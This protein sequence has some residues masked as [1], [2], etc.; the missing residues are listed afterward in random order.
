MRH[1]RHEGLAPVRLF[2]GSK[3]VRALLR[4]NSMPDVGSIGLSFSARSLVGPGFPFFALIGSAAAE[5]DQRRL[6]R[7]R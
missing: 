7:P 5:S 2:K 6:K 3:P 4:A 1:S